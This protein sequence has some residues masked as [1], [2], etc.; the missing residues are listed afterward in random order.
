[1]EFN[2]LGAP[3]LPTLAIE[4]KLT[5]ISGEVE[6][7]VGFL[8]SVIADVGALI[9]ARTVTAQG[10]HIVCVVIKRVEASVTNTRNPMKYLWKWQRRNE[11]RNKHVI[12]GANCSIVS[13]WFD[14]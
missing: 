11:G 4:T 13:R 3:H 14:S 10:P 8:D 9:P 12:E 5:L 6:Q 1:M 2:V 7:H